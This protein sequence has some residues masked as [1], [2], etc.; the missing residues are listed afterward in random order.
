MR[1]R[2]LAEV[3]QADDSIV[4]DHLVSLIMTQ[5]RENRSISPLLAGIFDA[6]PLVPT[7]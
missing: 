1:N 2:R 4:S 3:G 7:S 5:I 6:A